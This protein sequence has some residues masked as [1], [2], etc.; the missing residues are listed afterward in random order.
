M[1]IFSASVTENH[2]WAVRLGQFGELTHLVSLVNAPG[3]DIFES[4]DPA[5]EASRLGSAHLAFEVK[6]TALRQQIEVSPNRAV[7]DDLVADLDVIRGL[8]RADSA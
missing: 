5:K 7:A 1:E 8:T 3:N 4:R 6:V 2:E